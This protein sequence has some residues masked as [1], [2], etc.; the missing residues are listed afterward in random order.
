MNRAKLVSGPI[1]RIALM[2]G[3]VFAVGA[4][5]RLQPATTPLGVDRQAPPFS[6][7]D[8]NGEAVELKQALE[9]GPT[10]VV[11]YRGHW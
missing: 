5:A 6:L 8:Q 1:P 11:F 4:C 7:P 3:F 10:V 2:L 9:I